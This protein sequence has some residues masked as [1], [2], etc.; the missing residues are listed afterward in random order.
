[1]LLSYIYNSCNFNSTK[2]IEFNSVQWEIL[3]IHL[4]VE[5]SQSKNLSFQKSKTLSVSQSV[6]QS[7]GQSVSQSVSQSEMSPL[8]IKIL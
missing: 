5:Q 3:Q 2:F 8:L 4:Q 7:V 6:S 1:M